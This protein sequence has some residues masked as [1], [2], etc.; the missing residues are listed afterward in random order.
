M[1]K[2]FPRFRLILDIYVLAQGVKTGVYRM[3]DEVFPRLAKYE[4]FDVAFFVRQGFEEK[5]HQ[6]LEEK[7]IFDAGTIVYEKDGFAGGNILLSPFGVSPV[8]WEESSPIIRSHII[9]DLIGLR[10][11]EYL[12]E[13]GAAEVRRIIAGLRKDT[14][15]FAISECTKRDLLE[16]RPDLNPEL[17]VVIPLAA[18][19]RFFP[20]KD[21]HKRA[22][23]R[24]R[25]SIPQGVDYVL[26]LATLEIRKNLDQVVRAYVQ[27]MAA[28]PQSN[29][30]LVL[31]G[32]SGWK[33]ERLE[34][35]LAEAGPWRSKIVL[36]GYVEDQD[37]A[38]LYS[39]SK[40]F[41]YLSR[42]EGFGLPPL[43]AMAC[44]TP[45][46]VANNSSLPEVV[47]DAGLMV[48]ADDTAAA[49]GALTSLL[50]SEGDSEKYA[51]AAL[52]RSGDF[53]WDRCADTVRK[54]LLEAARQ[55]EEAFGQI[56]LAKSLSPMASVNGYENGSWGPQF[57]REKT[58][59]IRADGPWP[60]W[61]DSLRSIDRKAT[62]EGGLRTKG[63]FKN[64]SP[65]CPLVSY[66]T[67]V[68]NNPVTLARTIESVQQQSYKNVEH[69][70]LDGASTDN[71][72]DVIR[73]YEEKLDYYAS[74]PDKGLYDALNKAI[75]LARG[76]L[77]CVL[78]SDDWL[79]PDSAEIAVRYLGGISANCL[80]LSGARVLIGE[81]DVFHWVAA[82]VHPGSYFMCANACHN[83]IYATRLAYERSGPYDTSYKI[84][85]DFKWIMQCV[86][87]G[88]T[89]CY[90]RE[91]TV[92]Y[93]LGGVSSDNLNHSRECMRVV[94]ERFPFLSDKEREVLLAMFFVFATPE[95]KESGRSQGGLAGFLKKE[96]ALHALESDFV[97]ALA[98]A[99]LSA[100]PDVSH[101]ADRVI[102]IVSEAR[103][104]AGRHLPVEKIKSLLYRYPKF[105]NL[106][107]RIYWK[108]Q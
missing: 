49:V 26:S 28:N 15:V 24:Q 3:N 66:I 13:E 45:V 22:E 79:E 18:G 1:N 77:I 71:T 89:F 76:D 4:D 67:V 50:S 19:K 99:S 93:S 9:Y 74:E 91:A 51:Q 23:V 39:D 75:P 38:A 6:Y 84:A 107:R 14:I 60:I 68:R 90:T 56:R 106:A 72:L 102:G 57:Y 36:T 17:I 94:E 7:Q 25:Y 88:A 47:G 21:A 83:A 80:L 31:S 92:N 8:V 78:N 62:V 100:L 70:I 5:A 64:S 85:A 10:H 73:K 34:Q 12:T 82:F 41:F 48:D 33:L 35:A 46:I 55:R 104:N 101:P 86:D 98:W 16:Y 27:Y 103:K 2:I 95:Q 20:C 87:A 54:A 105:Y 65:E 81:N 43:E 96:Y 37:L 11:P 58:N 97:N 32:M 30:H 29:L 40:C 59:A 53:S 52:R 63:Q 42:Y 44:G 69:I 61:V 108:L